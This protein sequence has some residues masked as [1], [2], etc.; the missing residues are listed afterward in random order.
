MGQDPSRFLHT[1]LVVHEIP[2]QVGTKPDPPVLS[3]FELPIEDEVATFFR[4]R[5]SRSLMEEGVDV[6]FRDGATTK[7]P[8]LIR[9]MFV[10]E[11]AFLGLTQRM[12]IHLAE[13]QYA[14]S[15][16]GLLSIGLGKHE[17]RPAISIMKLEKA[18]G[19]R[20]QVV[21][22]GDKLALS[23]K[24]IHD[25]MLTQQTRVFKV[26][27][28]VQL[29]ADDIVGTVSDEQQ[30]GRTKVA[31]FFLADFLGCE[32]VQ[33][34]NVSTQRF[35]ETLIQFVNARVPDVTKRAEYM[36]AAVSELASN[37]KTLSRKAFVRNHINKPHQKELEELLDAQK[38][39]NTFQKD[40]A[41]I[42]AKLSRMVI[43]FKNGASVVAPYEIDKET[44]KID[45]LKDGRTKVTVQ[46]KVK[47]VSGRK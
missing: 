18:N 43:D 27:M 5:T 12:A 14:S 9:E 19:V 16:A 26:G 38:V 17:D 39:P 6:V 3:E 24:A 31:D 33:Q 4:N 20:V 10:N 8:D 11:D 22:H 23:P 35:F 30:R 44:F 32:L 1:R 36:R 45:N 46:D 13:A 37:S 25:L 40:N 42:K 41:A 21:H 29:G 7:V 34:P 2:R 15:N 28:F 47:K